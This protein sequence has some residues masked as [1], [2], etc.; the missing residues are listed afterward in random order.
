MF[1]AVLFDLDGTLLDIDMDF[2][3]PQYFGEMGR[4]AA[5]RGCCDPQLLVDQI[6]RSTEVMIQ[7]SDPASSNEEVFMEHFF[8]SLD[9]DEEQMRAFFAEFYR[10]G[11]PRLHKFSRPFQGVPEMMARL[12]TR[13]YKIVIATNAVFPTPAIQARLEWAGIGEFSYALLTCYENMHFCKPHV[14]YY[15]E[16]ADTIGVEPSRCLMVGNDTGE[17]LIA[18]KTGM[19]TFLVEDRMIDRGGNT[20]KPDWRGKLIDLYRFFDEM[21]DSQPTEWV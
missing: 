10:V 5:Q 6:L 7:D 1:E 12:F 2:F 19:K 4:M 13:D 20:H 9:T 11:F 17:D 21:A 14:Q 3:L 8:R 16:I 15:Q 18:S